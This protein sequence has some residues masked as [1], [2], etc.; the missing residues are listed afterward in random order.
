MGRF[1]GILSLFAVI[2]I[3]V[4][5]ISVFWL[6]SSNFKD[7]QREST[8]TL[9]KVLAYNISSQVK[10]LEKTIENIATNDE[11]IT[12]VDSNDAILVEHISKKFQ[13]ILPYALKLKIYL[14]D[15]N[16][17]DET[18]KDYFNYAD[19]NLVE[20]TFKGKQLSAVQGKNQNKH[21]TITTAIKKNNKVIGVILASLH[22]DFISNLFDKTT[23]E[24]NFVALKQGHIILAE[25][26]NIALKKT[27]PQSFKIA[28]TRWQLDY[29]VA[30]PRDISNIG[31]VIANITAIS[32]F[33]G[34]VCFFCYYRIKLALKKDQ[35]IILK[36]IKDLLMGKNIS[37]CSLNLAEM[38]IFISTLMKFK[39]V[40]D[41][42]EQITTRKK[43]QLN[44][45]VVSGQIEKKIK[46]KSKPKQQLNPDP[47][48]TPSKNKIE[49][50]LTIIKPTAIILENNE[51]KSIFKAYDI[52]GIA[53]KNLSKIKVYEIGLAIGTEVK[54]NGRKM[55]V[56]AKDGRC[57]STDLSSA[58]IK[59]LIST[60]C[61]VL[62]LGAVPTPLLYFITHHVGGRSGVMVTGS[63]HPAEYNGLKIV[64]NGEIL[65][66]EKIQR[67][68][69]LIEDEEYITETLG[70]VE[71]NDAYIEEYIG[72]ICDDILLKRCLKIVVDCGNGVG[73]TI[74]PILLESLGCEVIKLYCDIDGKFP[75]H[76]PDPCKPENLT[77]L[78]KTVQKNKAD[79]GLAFD[80][81]GNRLGVV[82]N[83]GNII[84]ADRQ[85]M[86]F[87]KQILAT[88]P[89]A[90]IIYDV[91]CSRHLV[92]YIKQHSGRPLMWKTG[93]SFLKEKMLET[94]AVL[95]G[96]LS[97]NIAFNDR[98]FGF[99]DALYSAARLLE[100][101]AADKR[102]CHEVF[103]ELPDSI[104]TPEIL[105]TMAVGENVKFMDEFT[106]LV[107]F[108]NAQIITIDGL[109]IEF[110]DG[111]ALIRASNSTPS[112]MLRFEADNK[113]ALLKIQKRIKHL[114]GEINEGI[115]FPF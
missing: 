57:S 100:I 82:D 95:A 81:A 51:D 68:Q 109:R 3:V 97:G 89:G 46:E 90:E 14:V 113:K 59:G 88:K 28:E 34:L 58:L 32:L 9:A 74:I 15:I 92:K 20:K 49:K 6:S 111:W 50:P 107:N 41:N 31:W 106:K 47:K 45:S 19:L 52:C 79:I 17:I 105:I 56:V 13:N 38:N 71:K 53:G 7:L 70:T 115:K 63:H 76:Q 99:D 44:T 80:G 1:F 64:I 23:I 39:R 22:T 10:L 5:S 43:E 2:M 12:A 69:K 98:W 65:A 84:W 40:L 83:L 94:G 35:A 48:K 96:G 29:M 36:A 93:H 112:I 30:A 24:N 85:I 27:K 110:E 60:G 101:L 66:G 91:K 8:L 42:K 102:A 108:P 33:T 11:V 25:A 26:G 104:N 54:Q 4:S 37:N 72:T 62:D 77:D 21:L 61:N 18:T 103:A 78:I 87:A 75:N 73:G 55:V 114:M 67:L 16:T 86:L